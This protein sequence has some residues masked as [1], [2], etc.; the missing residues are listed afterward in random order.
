MAGPRESDSPAQHQSSKS[1]K[2]DGRDCFYH[3]LLS[4]NP[5]PAQTRLI[6]A[7]ILILPKYLAPTP[8]HIGLVLGLPS[9][10]VAS[11]VQA[12]YPVLA[13]ENGTADGPVDIRVNSFKD[14]LIDQRRSFN[15]YINIDTEQHV[16]ARF[17][18]QN[19]STSKI[20]TYS[21]DQLYDDTTIRFFTQWIIFCKHESPRP[22]RGLLH[23]LRNVDLA[24]A[25]LS[26]STRRLERLDWARVF[27]E[28]ASWLEHDGNAGPI[29]P[30]HLRRLPQCFHLEWQ[31][32]MSLHDDIVYWVVRV[33]TG[34]VWGDWILLNDARGLPR[35]TECH[36]DLDDECIDDSHNP[37]HL[38][39]YQKTC[40]QVAMGFVSRFKTLVESS[41][42]GRELQDIFLNVV[43][44][45]LPKHCPLGSELFSLCRIFFELAKGSKLR[46]PPPSEVEG[47]RT[48][49]LEWI[50]ANLPK[51]FCWRSR[52]SKSTN[53]CLA[54]GTVGIGTVDAVYPEKYTAKRS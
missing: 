25:F 45:S 24:S 21:F 17:W 44:S 11:T 43:R 53:S 22:I 14:Y 35:V 8:A 49:L 36:C 23:S 27:R 37:Q 28:L 15:F 12:M 19:L 46:F 4:A 20:Q 39:A 2:Y 3:A 34:C 52:S 41:D 51:S 18:L 32:N 9:E 50:K 38:S 6:L 31:P 10:Q 33:M 40:L 7:A 5:H 42:E 30:D 13:F 54:V 48:N 47:A 1:S 26:F 16:I 29:A